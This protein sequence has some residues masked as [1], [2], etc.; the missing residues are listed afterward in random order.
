MQK[1]SKLP[2][3]ALPKRQVL[4]NIQTQISPVVIFLCL[5]SIEPNNILPRAAALQGHSASL[6]KSFGGFPDLYKVLEDCRFQGTIKSPDNMRP[7][8]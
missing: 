2:G 7:M 4:S 5:L 3:V 1:I 6:G 8:G